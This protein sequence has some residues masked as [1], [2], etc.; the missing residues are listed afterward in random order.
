LCCKA[1]VGRG[2]FGCGIGGLWCGCGGRVGWRGGGGVFRARLGVGQRAWVGAR[3]LYGC[4][5]WAVG[6]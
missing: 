6:W 5:V 4:A 3:G 2:G 1:C